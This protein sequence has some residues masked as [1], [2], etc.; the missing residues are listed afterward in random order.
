MRRYLSGLFIALIVFVAE[1][2]AWIPHDPSI[3]ENWILYDYVPMSF[4]WNIRFVV[5]QLQF[6]FA[7]AA[8]LVF[9]PSRFNTAAAFMFFCYC[10]LDSIMYFY[11]YKR[12]HY[13]I[14]Y[15]VIIIIFLL[16]YNRKRK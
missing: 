4:A 2:P 14:V 16:H 13:W 7:A 15:P 6:I 3:Q 5:S 8:L 1:I 12:E 9:T 10:V 11:N